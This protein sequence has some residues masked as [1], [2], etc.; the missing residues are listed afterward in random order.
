M[1]LSSHDE[2]QNVAMVAMLQRMIDHRA[3]KSLNIKEVLRHPALYCAQKKLDFLLKINESMKLIEWNKNE[4]RMIYDISHYDGGL[5]DDRQARKEKEFKI[6]FRDIFKKHPYF[7]EKMVTG[8]IAKKRGKWKTLDNV[9]NV[10]LLLIELRN[11]VAHACDDYNIPDD[12]KNNFL[13]GID[14]YKPEMFLKV[15]LSTCPELLVH[16][17]E[18]YRD[19][20]ERDEK[21]AARFYP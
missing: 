13:S 1:K 4:D 21:V 6:N 19:K 9:D 20:Y 16:L 17:Y 3:K 18:L 2:V 10:Q 7:I 8:K 11:K 14:S 12:F 15:F 5:S